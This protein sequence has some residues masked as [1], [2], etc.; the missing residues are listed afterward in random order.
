MKFI[1]AI[2]LTLGIGAALMSTT[3]SPAAGNQDKKEIHFNTQLPQITKTQQPVQTQEFNEAIRVIVP[4][5]DLESAIRSSEK[6]DILLL[7]SEGWYR[8]EN[9]T[10][11]QGTK[12]YLLSGQGSLVT[13]FPKE[14]DSVR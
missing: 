3:V 9:K 13:A 7:G 14:A 11:Q 2:M 6:G 12:I 8:L 1:S 5:K 10:L 4:Q